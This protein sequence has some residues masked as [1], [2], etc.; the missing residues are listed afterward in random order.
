M[1]E[2]VEHTSFSPQRL[3]KA[4]IFD[5]RME[6]LWF[7]HHY[8]RTP[9]CLQSYTELF[10]VVKVLPITQA[11]SHHFCTRGVGHNFPMISSISQRDLGNNLTELSSQVIA[12]PKNCPVSFCHIQL[13]PYEG[14]LVS[15]IL[16][17]CLW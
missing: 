12:I 7:F 8:L 17:Y 2:L 13:I 14:L 3:H 11:L 1:F 16:R 9:D 4:G 15:P 5:Q 6:S 10:G